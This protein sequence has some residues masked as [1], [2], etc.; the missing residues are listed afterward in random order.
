M[1]PKVEPIRF[2]DEG[3]EALVK[4]EYLILPTTNQQY[5]I[6][7]ALTVLCPFPKKQDILF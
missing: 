3:R 7:T 6:K 1:L 5:S 2:S 4:E